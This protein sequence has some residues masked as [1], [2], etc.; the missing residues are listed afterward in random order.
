MV[1]VSAHGMCAGDDPRLLRAWA[2]ATSF[3]PD[4]ATDAE[5]EHAVAHFA[6]L[7]RVEGKPLSSIDQT[8]LRMLTSEQ[9]YRAANDAAVLTEGATA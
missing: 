6:E 3:A 1:L 2:R 5:L 7:E 9:A 8:C 4:L